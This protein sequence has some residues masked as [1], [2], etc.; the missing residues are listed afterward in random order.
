MSRP[1][2]RSLTRSESRPLREAA[3]RRKKKKKENE[4]NREKKLSAN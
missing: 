1:D 2:V 4:R 3:R